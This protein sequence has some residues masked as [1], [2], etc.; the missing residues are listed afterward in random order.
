MT[1]NPGT[2]TYSAVPQQDQID[3]AFKEFKYWTPME[4]EIHW[5]P[6]LNEY[7]STTSGGYGVA[8]RPTF[9]V[10]DLDLEI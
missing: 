9:T 10:K 4:V 7:F 2:P 8:N 1:N 6:T 5:Y 3:L